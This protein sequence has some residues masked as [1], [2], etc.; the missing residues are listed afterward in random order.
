DDKSGAKFTHGAY[1]R[2]SK[3]CC[4]SWPCEGKR[5][6]TEDMPLRV[7]QR[8]CRHFEFAVDAG[9]TGSRRNNREGSSYKQL[10]QYNPSKIIC[11]SYALRIECFAATSIRPESS[12][13]QNAGSQVRHDHWE[14]NQGDP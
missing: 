6:S 14:K 13:K 8:S 7:A 10:R 1:P 2:Q 3:S 9:K 12:Q 5:N 4:Y 11:Q